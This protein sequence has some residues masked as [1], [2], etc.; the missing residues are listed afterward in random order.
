MRQIFMDTKFCYK[1]DYY[2][3][4]SFNFVY[5]ISNILVESQKG[6]ILHMITVC[7]V[8]TILFENV[9]K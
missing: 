5:D 9:V 8:V 7:V 3:L 6:Q 2:F 1:M 4:T